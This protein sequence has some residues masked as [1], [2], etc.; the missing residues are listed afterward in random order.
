MHV[1]ASGLG[2]AGIRWHGGLSVTA[3]GTECPEKGLLW[4][5]AGGVPDPSAPSEASWE[6]PGEELAFL[7]CPGTLAVPPASWPSG[8]TVSERLLNQALL[9]GF[10]NFLLDP[11][12]IFLAGWL[13]TF[14]DSLKTFLSVLVS[15]LTCHLWS[16][17]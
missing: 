14:C 1:V 3:G 16:P 9:G 5:L 7:C 17:S 4:N 11:I 10:A 2:A 13:P 12:R 6:H 8:T 15:Y